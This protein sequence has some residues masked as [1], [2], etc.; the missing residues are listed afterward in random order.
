MAKDLINLD[1]EDGRDI[2][3]D[4]SQTGLKIVQSGSGDVLGIEGSSTGDGL[5][6]AQTSTGKGIDI[7]VTTGDGIEIDGTGVLLDLNAN[8]TTGAYNAVD[9]VSANYSHPSVG[10]LKLTTSCSSGPA[11]EFT[12]LCAV[13]NASTMGE[14]AIAAVRVKV[15]SA[16]GTSW[17]WIPVVAGEGGV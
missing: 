10:L 8:D 12:G 6:L 14:T 5:S 11:L 9:I 3:T 2:I 16:A 15:T 4:S 17:G 7:S 13:S 1:A